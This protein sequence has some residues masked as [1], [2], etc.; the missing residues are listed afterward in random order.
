MGLLAIIFSTVP[1]TSNDSSFTSVS[2]NLPQIP[3]YSALIE[4]ATGVYIIGTEYGLFSSSNKGSTWYQEFQGPPQC[5]VTM[6]RQQTFPGSANRG[7]I[8]VA[9]HGRGLFTT[10]DYVTNTDEQSKLNHPENILTV[11]PNPS[12][13]SLNFELLR[14]ETKKKVS[15]ALKVAKLL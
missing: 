11:Y 5:P 10:K 14:E 9:T 7:Q 2:G 12:Y 6:I 13:K 1:V 4:D 15:E 3:I 8:Y